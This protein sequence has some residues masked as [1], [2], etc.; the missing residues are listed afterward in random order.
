M[1]STGNKKQPSLN[2]PRPTIFDD[3]TVESRTNLYCRLEDLSNEASVETFFIS[4]LLK[5]LGYKDS[6]IQPKKSLESLTVAR[7]HKREKY[8]PDY[9]LTVKRAPRCIIDA[10]GIE[11]NLDEWIEQCSG[12]CLALNR[13]IKGSNPVRYFVLSN[14]KTTKVYEWDKDEP[15]LVL[16]FSDFE[17]AN[18][19]YARLRELLGAD[20]IVKSTPSDAAEKGSDFAFIRATSERARQL[21]S[22]CHD[23]IWKSE[24]MQPSRAFTEFVKIIFVK[25]WEDR[26]LRENE[27]TRAH[28]ASG[29]AIVHLP[30]S[31]VKFSVEWVE[32]HER[33][34][35]LNPLDTI[36][37]AQ[38]RDSIERAIQFKKKK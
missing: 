28:F 26:A 34:G 27:A 25:L 29:G 37:F 35:V 32:S 6:Q 4:R 9:A 3:L 36:L 21:F 13:K 14:G 1:M 19:K 23:A 16:D 5:D 30:R 10:K 33:E 17:A 18:T 15:L 20:T 12:Y 11:E 38:L 2:Q 8:K 31:A 22:T 24:G 7:G